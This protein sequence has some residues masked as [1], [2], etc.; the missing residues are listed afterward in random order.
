MYFFDSFF[1][2]FNSQGLFNRILVAFVL[3][4]IP[5][6]GTLILTGY[7]IKIIGEV[8]KENKDLPEFEFGADFGRGL[9]A[10]VAGLV[11]M[12]P[13]VILS[14]LFAATGIQPDGTVNFALAAVAALVSLVLLPVLIVAYVRFGISGESSTLFE[15]GANVRRVGTKPSAAV[16]LYV[17]MLLY[18][19]FVF[20]AA[21]IGTALFI[22]PG[23]IIMTAAQLGQYHLYAQYGFELEIGGKR[24]VV[25][26]DSYTY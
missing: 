7:G 12:L 6:V 10:I 23:L 14:G 3:A 20:V 24:K 5:V 15:I 21:S 22:I 2:P 1:Y 4:L 18:G 16:M 8:Y 9:L 25:V 11:Y 13:V 17:N 26:D 19:I